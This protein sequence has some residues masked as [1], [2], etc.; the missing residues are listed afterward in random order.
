MDRIGT[1]GDNCTYCPRYTA[2][3]KNDIAA[4]ERVKDLYIR[5]GLRNPD[6][7]TEKMVC[8][9]CEPENKC[10]YP[11]LAACLASKTIENCGLCETYPCA[12]IIIAFK[13]S[14][15]F[16]SIAEKIC[17]REEMKML[18]KAFFS[19]QDYFDRIHR[20]IKKKNTAETRS[21]KNRNKGKR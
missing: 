6:F 14:D 21:S 8:H 10:A 2:T 4:L 20:K 16:R 1:C 13:K 18:D 3:Q 9:G 19:K 7:P 15:Q 12:L 5:L 11:E 17:T